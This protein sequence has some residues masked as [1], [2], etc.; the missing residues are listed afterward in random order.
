MNNSESLVFWRR[1]VI[2]TFL[3]LWPKRKRLNRKCH[4]P[5]SVLLRNT[6]PHNTCYE[7]REHVIRITTHKS[8]YRKKTKVADKG[9]RRENIQALPTNL[10]VKFEKGLQSKISNDACI[11]TK[12]KSFEG[13]IR[14]VRLV[15]GVSSL[16]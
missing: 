6:M 8:G 9:R 5:K 2:F 14:N 1:I 10:L 11:H 13:P 15:E 12:D 4:R 16:E 7:N 3:D